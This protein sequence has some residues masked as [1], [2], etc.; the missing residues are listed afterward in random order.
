MGK[1]HAR[2]NQK[3][4]QISQNI[5]APVSTSRDECSGGDNL[6]NVGVT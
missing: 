4:L 5:I 2:C 3:E 6:L 1:P